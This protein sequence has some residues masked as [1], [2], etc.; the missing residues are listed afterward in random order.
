LALVGISV[1]P[2][3][4]LF[5]S[6]F[7]CNKDTYWLCNYYVP[8]AYR[9]VCNN[10]LNY[11]VGDRCTIRSNDRPR[12]KGC[13]YGESSNFSL[14]EYSCIPGEGIT[15]DLP[16]IDICSNDSPSD[17]GLLHSPNYPHSLGKYLSCKKEFHIT[18][19]SRLRLF[20]LEKSI[21]YFH[22]LNIR[23][24]NNEPN[25]QRTLAKNELFDTNITAQQKD[26]IVEIEL[27]TNHVGGGNFLL[28]FQG[29][30]LVFLT[31]NINNCCI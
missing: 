31:V 17:R 28:Y 14:V 13:Q 18:R 8:D 7:K 5:K 6:P 3:N 30:Y 4:D 20:M 1:K 2:Q 25:I 22:E 27:K 10:Q 24:L 21:E 26:E 11:G 23:L 9:N 15:E 12:L 29:N 16:R 19:E